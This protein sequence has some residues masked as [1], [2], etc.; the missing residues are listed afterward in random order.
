MPPAAR[1][2]DMHTCPKEE[3]GPTPHVGGTVCNGEPTVLIANQPAARKGD[4]VICVGAPDRVKDGSPTV[5]IGKKRAARKGDPT[6]HDGIII[7]GVPR[8]KIGDAPRSSSASGGG[9]PL[10]EPC[11]PGGGSAEPDTI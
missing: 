3:P 2:T 1:V 11:S 6:E 9:A 5:L 4:E 7:A 10:V 8:V